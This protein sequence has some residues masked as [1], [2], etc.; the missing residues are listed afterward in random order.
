MH[1]FCTVLLSVY[2][3]ILL[4]VCMVDYFFFFFLMIR[5]P[6][7]STRTDTLV[8]YTTLFRSHLAAVDHVLLAVPHRA[9]L[10]RRGVE[11][12]VRLGHAEAGLL[13]ALDQR[14]QPAPLLLVRAVHDDRVRAE[15]VDVDRRGAGK[16][17]ARLGDR[18]EHDRRLGDT[19]PRAAIRLR[20]GDAEPAVLRH[21]LIEVLGEAAL[22]VA[23][24]PVVRPEILAELD[25]GILDLLLL[26]I[27]R[28][29]CRERVCQYV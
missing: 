7:R 20:H 3:N 13:L 22:V 2:R 14:H 21:R 24:Q 11:A 6:P 23:L 10:D 12:G 15:D 28:A 17:R 1:Y 16:C 27:G 18:L 4:V 25:Y 29:S 8:P 19:E 5:R 26:E 9:R